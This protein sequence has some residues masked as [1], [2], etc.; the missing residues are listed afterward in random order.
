M[1]Y[2]TG[3]FRSLQA[4]FILLYYT[5]DPFNL[6]MFVFK[7]CQRISFCCFPGVSEHDVSML[8]VQLNESISLSCSMTDRYEISWYHQNPESGRLTLLMSAKTSS[9]AGRKLLVRYNQNW[10][11]LTVKADVGIDTVTL[12]I[13]G[14][15]ESDSGLYFCGTRSL[16]MH[17]DKPIRLVMEG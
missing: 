5:I 8:R 6:Q 3:L 1:F 14:L 7:S 16:E 9:V 15:T 4:V 12:V 13:S 11:R 2:H 17:F 10:S